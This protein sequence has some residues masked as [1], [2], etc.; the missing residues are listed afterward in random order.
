MTIISAH[1]YYSLKYGV[2]S[3]KEV[4]EEAEKHGYR[5]VVLTDIN[6]TSASLNFVRIAHRYNIRPVL[7]VDFRNGAEPCFLAIAQNNQGFQ[8]INT[9]LSSFLQHGKEEPIPD[10]APDWAHVTVIYPFSKVPDA[11][12]AFEY[13]GIRAQEINKLKFSPL[14]EKKDRLVACPRFSF[15]GKRDFNA[16]R[17]LRAIDN[18][19]LLS[20]LSKTEEGE[21]GDLFLSKQSLKA[22]YAEMPWLLEQ[23]ARLV[24]N[25]HIE[26]DFGRNQNKRIFGRSE[27][28]DFQQLKSLTYAGVGYRYPDP[29]DAV[30]DRIAKELSIIREKG[31]TSYFLV[32]RDIIRYARSK[33]YFH[34]GRGSGANSIVAYCLGI[35]DV[36]P[37]DL[38]LYFERFINLY[39]EN[40]PDF[41]LDFSWKDRDDV[42]RYIFEKHGTVHC[43]LLATY[44]TFQFKSVIRELGK[45]FGLPK[46]EI[47]QLQYKVKRG[48][49]LD[50]IESLVLRY[51]KYIHGFPSHL[52]VHAGGILISERPIHHFTATFVP[53]KGFPTTHFDMVIAEDAGLYK[54]DILS[55]RGLG[56]IRDTVEEVERN[57]QKQVDIHDIKAFKE[58][59]RI[60]QLISTGR[61]MGCFYVESPAMRMLLSK[62]ETDD[63]LGLVAASSIIRPGVARSGMMREYILRHR[64]PE[65]R[66]EAHPVMR[67]LMP[68]TYGVMVYQ[69][70]VIKVAHYFA[71][72]S[73]AEAD[74]LRRGMSG[75]YRSREEFARA[76]DKF[77]SNCRDK[78]YSDA[79]TAEIWRQTESFAGYA[80]SKG[81][82]AS[83]AVES[84]Q[85]LYLKAHYPLE[86]MVGVINN[87][88]GFYRT[89]FYVHEARMSGANIC[90]PCVNRSQYKTTIYDADIYL[91][92]VHMRSLEKRTISEILTEREQ[93]G[94]FAHMGDF[95]DRVSVSLEQLKLLIRMN[96]F[97]FT[98]KN[99]KELMWEAHLHVHGKK[100]VARKL[101][102]FSITRKNYQLPPLFQEDLE[103]AFDQLEL[104]GF[105][106][107]SPFRLVKE[108][109]QNRLRAVHLA[110]FHGKR[111]EIFGYMVTVKETRTVKGDRMNFGTWLDMDGAFFDTVHFPP[112]ARKFPFRGRAIYRITGTVTEEFGFFSVEVESMERMEY[113]EDP[114]Y[115]EPALE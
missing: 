113:I 17:L 115:S 48:E 25:C 108:P 101:E 49:T 68:E 22:D 4:L 12:R 96:A 51:S 27:E 20:K 40:P 8:E 53:P 65:K 89:E 56:H 31:F 59:P 61:T 41:D 107:I 83:Y 57:Q 79:L 106:L 55:Q 36:D 73:L 78:G 14:L 35:T 98:G 80:F 69:E 21:A 62:L 103:D 23:S 33:G 102:L 11:L 99:K 16:H 38:D 2:M 24:Q 67:K 64:H 9:Y 58:D 109:I 74:V 114:R 75:K 112:V 7:G 1:T 90:A 70:D 34:V 88:G 72:L 15:R 84:Y 39:R 100:N 104:L 85:S 86:F 87:F 37:I 18:N 66:K 105:S 3:E 54:Y 6:N 42:T 82:S 111:V 97:R 13:I 76:R 43:C 32:N 71:G 81:H 47:D 60:R 44:I 5:T 94:T 29:D 30:F 95:L 45:V 52:S 10:R 110:Q 46:A 50:E 28:E 92:F 63:Y 91:G 19:V 93:N 77:F 26:F